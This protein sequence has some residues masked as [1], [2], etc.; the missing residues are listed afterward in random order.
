MVETKHFNQNPYTCRYA[1][2]KEKQHNYIFNKTLKSSLF[3]HIVF[4]FFFGCS[5]H[6]LLVF[7]RCLLS[8]PLISTDNQPN[9]QELSLVQRQV[10]CRLFFH[11][12]SIGFAVTVTER[13][14]Y[15]IIVIIRMNDLT[16][17]LELGTEKNQ[18][19]FF[20]FRSI[21]FYL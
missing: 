8:H 3:F 10:F 11:E 19:W 13:Q 5:F 2:K 4:R 1:A 7:G 20:S 16:N 15:F 6:S 18:K 9:I 12:N 17:T 14:H 21:S